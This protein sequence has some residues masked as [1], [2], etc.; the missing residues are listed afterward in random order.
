MGHSV[1]LTALAH[2]DKI[3][4]VGRTHEN[5]LEQMQSGW[6]ESNCLG[7]LCD[8]RVRDTVDAVIQ[9]SLAHWGRIDIIVKYDF[10]RT[11]RPR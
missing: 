7:L 1:A 3:T 9:Q 11:I 5:S 8:V 4:A 2:G 6:H 10:E